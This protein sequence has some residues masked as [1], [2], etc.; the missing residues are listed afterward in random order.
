MD[1]LNFIKL[2]WGYTYSGEEK[3]LALLLNTASIVSMAR[4]PEEHD[5]TNKTRVQTSTGI[6][7]DVAE[8]PEEVMEM[9][10]NAEND[11]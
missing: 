11:A 1:K 7:Y 4:I 6:V 10:R 3:P 5:R 9:I 2:T 8:T